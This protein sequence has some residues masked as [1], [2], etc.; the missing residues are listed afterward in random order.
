MFGALKPYLMAKAEAARLRAAND[1]RGVFVG[2]LPFSRMPFLLSL[3]GLLALMP[4]ILLQTSFSIYS[5]ARDEI[6]SQPRPQHSVVRLDTLELSIPQS[7][8]RVVEKGPNYLHFS[9]Q[10]IGLF[11]M[12][13]IGDEEMRLASSLNLKLTNVKSRPSARTI[14]QGLDALHKPVLV[15]ARDSGLE[16]YRL[17]NGPITR[18]EHLILGLPEEEISAHEAPFFGVCH[19]DAETLYA[20]CTGYLEAGTMFIEME[21]SAE[22]LDDWKAITALAIEFTERLKEGAL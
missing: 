2:M 22:A 6:V 13:R 11:L 7:L 14:L 9:M 15:E 4:I 1:C 10:R 21:F 12:P 16:V 8:E 20:L 5:V 19:D 3:F 17:A 18:A